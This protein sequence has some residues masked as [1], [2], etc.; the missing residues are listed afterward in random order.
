M[1]DAQAILMAHR[2]KCDHIVT[3]NGMEIGARRVCYGC[4]IAALNEERKRFAEGLRRWADYHEERHAHQVHHI[5]ETVR[6]QADVVREAAAVMM[7]GKEP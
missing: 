5:R 2:E 7:A 6:H 4:A 1:V 3:R